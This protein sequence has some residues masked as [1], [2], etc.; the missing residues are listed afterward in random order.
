MGMLIKVLQNW[1]KYVVVHTRLCI[2]KTDCCLCWYL[3]MI[4]A[5]ISCFMCHSLANLS[6]NN[7]IATLFNSSPSVEWVCWNQAYL[8]VN[9][10]LL[11]LSGTCVVIQ[12]GFNTAASLGRRSKRLHT[13]DL[14]WCRNL[15][16]EAVGFIVDN[17]LS[18]RMLK[19]FG[20]TQVSISGLIS[21]TE[22][23]SFWNYDQFYIHSEAC[24]EIFKTLFNR[25]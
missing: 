5:W 8:T 25:I 23:Q 24:S 7:F 18:L 22:M 16:D 12:V 9:D 20:C 2:S 17:C 1:F 10:V 21:R 13:L 14:S 19:L 15:T 4:C 6:Y 3:V 11:F